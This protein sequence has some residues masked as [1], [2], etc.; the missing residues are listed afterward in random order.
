MRKTLKQILCTLLALCVI[1]QP[2]AVFAE[3]P[4]AGNIVIDVQDFGAD[5]TGVKDSTEAIWNALQE[6]KNSLQVAKT[7]L[8]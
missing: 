3:E 5:P 1:L 6:A 7:M 8:H 4:T 2:V